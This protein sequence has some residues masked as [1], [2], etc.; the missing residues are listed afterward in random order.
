MSRFAGRIALVTGAGGGIGREV[1]EA[2]AR[3]GARVIVTDIDEGAAATVAAAIHGRDGDAFAIRQDARDPE[4][5][6]RVVEFG[7][8]TFGGLHL[9]VN[10]AGIGSVIQPTGEYPLDAWSQVIDTNLNG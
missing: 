1:A 2:L 4:D 5:T 8:A 10:N 7:I 3:E 6:R 9:A